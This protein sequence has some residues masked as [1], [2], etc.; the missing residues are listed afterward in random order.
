MTCGNENPKWGSS[1]SVVGMASLPQPK[2]LYQAWK[3]RNVSLSFSHFEF[4][5][6]FFFQEPSGNK[7][8]GYL[9]IFDFHLI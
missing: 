6:N 8:Y 5:F 7:S 3:G 4:S 9:Y 2:R 1:S